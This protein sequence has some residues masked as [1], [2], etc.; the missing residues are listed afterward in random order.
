MKLNLRYLPKKLTRKDRLLQGKEILKSR[1]LYKKK[2]Y[3]SRP[4][5]S[6][7]KSKK[8]HFIIKAVNIYNVDKIGYFGSFAR[9]E[10]T[11]SSDID[12]IVSFKKPLGWAFFDLQELLEKELKR[13]VD[14]VTFNALKEQLKETILKE[15]KYV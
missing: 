14:L 12:I 3:H 7:F 15:I 10:Q 13:K 8:S 6:S 9:N 1:K 2:I 4:K 5:V 11:E